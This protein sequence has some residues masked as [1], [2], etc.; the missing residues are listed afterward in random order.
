MVIDWF[1]KYCHFLYA[2]TTV[3]CLFFN[4]TMKLHGIPSS[5]VSDRDLV[6]TGNFWW[7]LFRLAGVKLKLSSAFHPQLD[8]Q[9]EVTNKIIAKYLQRLVG[10]RSSTWLQWLAWAEFCY[11]SSVEALLKTSPFR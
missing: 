7:E 6:F 2:A 11:N 3:V 5:I 8:G 9:S 1:S 10:D 4:K